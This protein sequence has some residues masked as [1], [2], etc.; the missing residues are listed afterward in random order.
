MFC[1]KKVCTLCTKFI[2]HNTFF[3]SVQ[4]TNYVHTVH[5]SNSLKL[6][7]LQPC[8]PTWIFPPPYCRIASE[9][10]RTEFTAFNPNQHRRGLKSTSPSSKENVPISLKQF[11]VNCFF[12]KQV[13]ITNYLRNLLF[14]KRTNNKK[15][16]YKSH[17]E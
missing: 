4:G 7:L 5:I 11:S 16:T 10:A 13:C 8:N 6:K 12:K 1:L 17:N 9:Y 2:I 15:V 14:V 3:D